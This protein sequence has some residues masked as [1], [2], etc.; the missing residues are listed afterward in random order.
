MS[1]A[2]LW[3]YGYRFWSYSVI[4]MSQIKTIAHNCPT[5]YDT[6]QEYN[7]FDVL[8]L[9]K[10]ECEKQNALCKRKI[11]IYYHYLEVNISCF[12]T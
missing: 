5:E 8:C 9:G 4:F 12:S 11:F 1:E 7:V 3:H 2:T 6:S 10:N